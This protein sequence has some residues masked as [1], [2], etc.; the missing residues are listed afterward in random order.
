M[1]VHVRSFV[2]ESFGIPGSNAFKNQGIHYS[3]AVGDAFGF[4]LPDCLVYDRARRGFVSYEPPFVKF[5]R[6]GVASSGQGAKW[7]RM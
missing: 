3:G 1:L 2:D 6:T 7:I 5:I 4:G